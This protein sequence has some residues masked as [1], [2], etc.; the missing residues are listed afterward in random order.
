M[1]SIP[2][3]VAQSNL[4]RRKITLRY[5]AFVR[6]VAEAALIACSP[7]Y[8]LLRPGLLELEP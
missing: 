4:S 8:V 5:A 1:S 6:K 2:H 7:D 3:G